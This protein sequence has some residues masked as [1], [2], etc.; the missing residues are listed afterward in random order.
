MIAIGY[1][2]EERTTKERFNE[3]KLHFEKW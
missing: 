1:K 3:E 2:A